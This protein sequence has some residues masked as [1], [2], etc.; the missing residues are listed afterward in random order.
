MTWRKTGEEFD[1]ECAHVDMTDAAYRTHVEGIGYVYSVGAMDCL[2]PK[3]RLA[4]IANS[5]ETA[6]AVKELVALGFWIDRDDAYEVAHHGD[7]IRQSLVAQGKKLDRDKRA[8]KAYR[9]RKS[10]EKEEPDQGPSVSADVSGDTDRQTDRHLP[11]RVPPTCKHRYTPGAEVDPWLF[12]AACDL[13][14]K[15]SERKSA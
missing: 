5:D 3:R 1:N 8:A 2:I 7:V 11:E 14:Q 6:E 10:K 4:K 15:E 12:V 9:D 13:C